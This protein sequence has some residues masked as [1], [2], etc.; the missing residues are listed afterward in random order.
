MQGRPIAP[1]LTSQPVNFTPREDDDFTK[2]RCQTNL[3]L[4]WH[5]HQ[6]FYKE[7]AEGVCA[8]PWVR[9]HALKDYYGM[10]AC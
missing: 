5:M 6:P 3:M 9:L 8:M 4:L 1:A 7:L 2:P 10:V